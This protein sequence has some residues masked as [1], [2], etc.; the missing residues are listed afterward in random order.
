MVCKAD[1]EEVNCLNVYCAFELYY[2]FKETFWLWASLSELKDSSSSELKKAERNPIFGNFLGD[3]VHELR[4]SYCL[5]IKAT[6]EQ[7]AL[8]RAGTIGFTPVGYLLKTTRTWR[9]FQNKFPKFS[10]FKKE[11]V[12]SG[13]MNTILLIQQKSKDFLVLS[14]GDIGKV[15]VHCLLKCLLLVLS[16]SCVI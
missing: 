9:Y 15:V 13:V 2:S 1:E 5:K 10:S 3:Q 14:F 6:P 7:Q 12:R 4:A 11:D 16:W 8:I